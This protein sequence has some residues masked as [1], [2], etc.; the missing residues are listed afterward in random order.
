MNALL[1]YITEYEMEK[2]DYALLCHPGMRVK[3]SFS[4]GNISQLNHKLCGNLGL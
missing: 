4:I 2:D 1:N 3:S